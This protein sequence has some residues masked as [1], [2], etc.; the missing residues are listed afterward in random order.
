MS[1]SDVEIGAGDSSRRQIEAEDDHSHRE[2]KQSL[3]A[4]ADFLAY[5]SNNA[6]ESSIRQALL[7]LKK[8][9]SHKYEGNSG[10]SPS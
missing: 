3:V 6:S 4:R 1:A 2:G 10:E 7:P 9:K 8:E 5:S